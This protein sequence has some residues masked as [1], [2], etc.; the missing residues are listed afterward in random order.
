MSKEQEEYIGRQVLEETLEEFR[1]RI[2]PSDH[3]I[4]QQVR[5]I[6]RRILTASNLGQ[7]EG[8]LPPEETV[9]SELSGLPAAEI[10]RPPT[11]HPDKKW[12][13]LVVNDR[14]LVNAFAAPGLVCVFTGI[15]PV[16]RN[17]EGLAA[18]I[19]HGV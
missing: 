6:T 8:D 17:E 9:W 16:A 4:T 1:G 14:K 18:I 3:P 11:M 12:T 7:L 10:P 5:R 2:L 19:G 13:V 15:M